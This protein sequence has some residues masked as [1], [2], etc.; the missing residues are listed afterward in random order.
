MPLRAAPD[1]DALPAPA[2]LAAGTGEGTASLGCGATTG[3]GSAFFAAA[4]WGL[5][6][7]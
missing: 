6:A 3:E 7:V 4:P 1:V 2:T 5:F